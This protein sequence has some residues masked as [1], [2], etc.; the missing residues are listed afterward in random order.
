MTQ[1]AL[2][3][4]VEVAGSQTSLARQVGVSQSTLWHWLNGSRRGAPAEVCEQ[5]EAVTGISRHELRPDVFGA[6][7][8]V[9]GAESDAEV[10]A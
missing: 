7:P 6:A 3:R 8:V 2:R 10:A 9:T 1:E 4:A 5:I